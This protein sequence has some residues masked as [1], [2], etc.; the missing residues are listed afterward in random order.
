MSE[1]S[2]KKLT[3]FYIDKIDSKNS[4]F[5]R[6][7]ILPFYLPGS[8]ASERL[9][10]SLPSKTEKVAEARLRIISKTFI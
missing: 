3:V 7:Y 9:P 4:I 8:I 6:R 10:P 1:F 5:P 2:P